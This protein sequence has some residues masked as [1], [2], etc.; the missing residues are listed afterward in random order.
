MFKFAVGLAVAKISEVILRNENAILPVS[1][2]LDGQY[3]IS[4]VALSIPCIVNNSG[5]KKKIIIEMTPE[6]KAK[7]TDSADALKEI[8]QKF[9]S[10][11]C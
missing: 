11:Y 5:I 2:K 10:K 8:I 4:D 7:L 1:V 6:E 3:D 9:K